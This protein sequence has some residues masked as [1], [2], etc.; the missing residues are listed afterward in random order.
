MSC[1]LAI[2]MLLTLAPDQNLPDGFYEL[3]EEIRG[4]ATLIVT[5]TYSEGRS[6]CIVRPGGIRAWTVESV[7]KITKVHRGEVGGKFIY[8][9]WSTLLK[10]QAGKLT[11]GQKY[12]VLLRPNEESMKA[13]REGKYVPAWNALY[14][15]EIIAIVELK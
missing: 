6:P 4:Q 12:L 8:L 7:M 2:A 14:D 1:L 15:E 5:G 13:I 9:S 3:P 11:P 10:R